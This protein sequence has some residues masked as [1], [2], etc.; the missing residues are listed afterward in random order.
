MRR[1]LDAGHPGSFDCGEKKRFAV[2]TS[3]FRSR[4]LFAGR[5]VIDLF[6]ISPFP[7][8]PFSRA[9]IPGE[10]RDTIGHYFWAV[11]GHRVRRQPNT[12]A[13]V[14]TTYEMSEHSAHRKK[15]SFFS[16][17]PKKKELKVRGKKI[18]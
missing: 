17:K 15:L 3:G 2:R 1:F 6:T 13:C 16:N 18:L 7:R 12:H 4:S 14:N 11:S 9:E 8:V 10:G 5:L